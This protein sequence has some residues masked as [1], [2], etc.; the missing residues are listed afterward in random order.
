MNTDHCII[1]RPPS[2]EY[3]V[4]SKNFLFVKTLSRE[5][6]DEFI[7]SKFIE[8]HALAIA[9]LM[10]YNKFNDLLSLL[11]RGEDYRTYVARQEAMTYQGARQRSKS[12]PT[13]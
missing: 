4:P 10:R 3:S 5:E 7:G 1:I 13:S 6:N 8:W 2:L 12:K 11:E 9:C